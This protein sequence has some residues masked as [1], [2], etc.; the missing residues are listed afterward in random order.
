MSTCHYIQL[1]RTLLAQ[2]AGLYSTFFPPG[3][4][5]NYHSQPA[6]SFQYGMQPDHDTSLPA[7]SGSFAYSD[8]ASQLA[9][10]SPHTSPP[11]TSSGG[12]ASPK[13]S[14]SADARHSDR[15]N[16]PVEMP[17]K[18]TGK[19]PTAGEYISR[20]FLCRYTAL[21]LSVDQSKSLRS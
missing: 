16:T 11:T 8:A 3:T 7:I 1:K 14:L 21:M 20:L 2:P 5:E 19:L 12:H 6:S 4:I 13:Q 9:N 18:R 17:Q 15:S 10:A